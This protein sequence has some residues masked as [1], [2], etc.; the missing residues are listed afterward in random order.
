MNCKNN[1]I[2]YFL[3]SKIFKHLPFAC[4]ECN[5]CAG[6]EYRNKN[7][8]RISSETNF[9]LNYERK[10][11]SRPLDLIQSMN[12]LGMAKAIHLCTN[13]KHQSH[14][15]KIKKKLFWGAFFFLWKRQKIILLLK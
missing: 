1:K 10:R 14:V 9:K 11:N 5:G 12:S 2:R 13:I 7:I 6:S 4:V 15:V 8:E 3:P